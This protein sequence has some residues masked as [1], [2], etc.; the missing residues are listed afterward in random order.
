MSAENPEW[1]KGWNLDQIRKYELVMAITPM[2]NEDEI[3]SV[4]EKI[5]SYVNKNGGD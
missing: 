1:T 4:L 3:N 5:E 2:S